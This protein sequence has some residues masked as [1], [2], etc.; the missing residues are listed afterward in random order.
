MPSLLGAQSARPT[1]Y[2]KGFAPHLNCAYNLLIRMILDLDK[3]ERNIRV[4]SFRKANDRE[5]KHH[6]QAQTPD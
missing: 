6:A 3:N 2:F 4:S 1:D 5:V